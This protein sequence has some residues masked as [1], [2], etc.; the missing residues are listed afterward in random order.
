MKV[1]E[2]EEARALR[3]EAGMSMKAIARQLEV[4]VSSVSSGR[5]TSS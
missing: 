1:K 5:E 2:R 3:R 4:S